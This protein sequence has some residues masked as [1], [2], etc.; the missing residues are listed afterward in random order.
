MIN[1]CTRPQNPDKHAHCSL[2]N[3]HFIFCCNFCIPRF[4]ASLSASPVG[5]TPAHASE[6]DT[7]SAALVLAT[8]QP[9]RTRRETTSRSSKSPHRRHHCLRRPIPST[10][11]E[12][13]KGL[14]RTYSTATARSTYPRTT[15]ARRAQP[16]FSRWAS[17]GSCWW[18]WRPR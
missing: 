8:S 14:M 18:P 4:L 17:A 15:G 3:P 13:S 6:H 1:G 9:W 2:G 16:M 7:T 5:A 12:T 10:H 11:S